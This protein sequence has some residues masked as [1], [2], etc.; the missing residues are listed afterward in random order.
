MKLAYQGKREVRNLPQLICMIEHP[1]GLAN[2]PDIVDESELKKLA[3]EW[4]K[5]LNIKVAK[6]DITMADSKDDL[7][8]EGFVYEISFQETLQALA[9]RAGSESG[10][11]MEEVAGK[12]KTEMENMMERKNRG[13]QNKAMRRK[14]VETLD[15]KVIAQ[16]QSLGSVNTKSA[17]NE[18][19]KAIAISTEDEEKKK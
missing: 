17:N 15:L 5:G 13:Q 6:H 8:E 11:K 9:L 18:D 4:E 3:V 2:N 14:T 1:L 12:V 16:K 19:A 10:F 7:D